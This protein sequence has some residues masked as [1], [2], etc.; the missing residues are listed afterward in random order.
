M[1]SDSLTIENPFDVCAWCSFPLVEPRI[2]YIFNLS[3]M[4]VIESVIVDGQMVPVFGRFKSFCCLNCIL[5]SI[6]YGSGNKTGI[7]R[8]AIFTWANTCRI[9]ELTKDQAER[10]S[11][12]LPFAQLQKYGGKMTYEEYHKN[13]VYPNYKYHDKDGVRHTI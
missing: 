5:A 10:I 7:P 3:N 13:H 9:Y 11:P 8:E 6:Q 1:T 12:S 2:Y 4:P